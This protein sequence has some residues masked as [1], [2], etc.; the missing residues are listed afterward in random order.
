MILSSLCFALMAVAVKL[1]GDIPTI[2]KVF[3]RN[4]IGLIIAATLIFRSKGSFL[5]NNRR[6]LFLRAFFGL[7]GLFLYFYAIDNLPLA[8]AVILNQL[9]PFF[10]LVLSAFFLGERILRGQ[11][12]AL[13]LALGGVVFVV[14]PEFNYTM[15]PALAALFSAFFA[16]AA[17]TEVRNLRLTDHPQT[18]V[19][20]FT[21]LTTMVSIPFLL[22]GHFVLPSFPQFVALVAVGVF[23]TLAQ[24][25]LTH[26]YRYAEAG[27]LSIYSYG[28]TIF[29]IMTGAVVFREFP[30]MFSFL[31]VFLILS[32]AFLNWRAKAL[33]APAA[34][35]PGPVK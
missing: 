34:N 2:E 1:S 25:L 27:D 8:S 35:Q 14:K 9:S 29:S 26:A 21:A 5:G 23:A 15:A 20:Y 28:L 19:F 12:I 6:H 7:L 4:I 30:D 11:G 32:G 13:V 31:G 24:F 22:A 16:A 17:Y 18:I 3:F 33:P 10:V